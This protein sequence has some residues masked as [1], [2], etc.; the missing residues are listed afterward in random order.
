MFD[1]MQ[2]GILGFH[3]EIGGLPGPLFVYLKRSVSKSIK[4]QLFVHM[5]SEVSERE[6]TK[7]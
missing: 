6:V 5:E 3:D 7:T 2:Q 4:L 1:V